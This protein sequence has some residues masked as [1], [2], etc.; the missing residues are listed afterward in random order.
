MHGVNAQRKMVTKEFKTATIR[1]NGFDPIWN[2]VFEFDVE[3]PELAQLCFRCSHDTSLGAQGV[4]IAGVSLPII[5]LRTGFRMIQL[6]DESGRKSSGDSGFA[7]VF[8]HLSI[9]STQV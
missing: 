1:Q 4:F 6:F 8:A 7:S 5:Y 3:F 2:Q 9:V